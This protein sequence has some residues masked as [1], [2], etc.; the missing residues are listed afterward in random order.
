MYNSTFTHPLT[1]EFLSDFLKQVADDTDRPLHVLAG[2]ILGLPWATVRG[3]ITDE[4]DTDKIAFGKDLKLAMAARADKM[5]NDVVEIIDDCVVESA[6][7]RKAELR[8]KVRHM[9]A[10]VLSRHWVERQAHDIDINKAPDENPNDFTKLDNEEIR[11]L[12]RIQAKMR[13]ASA[14]D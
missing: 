2:D 5:M 11:E 6:N 8:G 13:E 1:T 10:K 9:H 3:W 14:G 7:I 12:L 4:A